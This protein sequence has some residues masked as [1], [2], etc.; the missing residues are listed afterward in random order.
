MEIHHRA[1]TQTCSYHMFL[2]SH[3]KQIIGL[4]AILQPDLHARVVFFSEIGLVFI[5]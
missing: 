2:V 1:T 4:V 3:Q 5:V